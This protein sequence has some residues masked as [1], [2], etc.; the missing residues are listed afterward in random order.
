M[1]QVPLNMVPRDRRERERKAKVMK[2]RGIEKNPRT[3]CVRFVGI[4]LRR[5]R[6][7]C[8]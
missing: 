5:D 1:P 3:G 2:G 4:M 8:T 6:T 7:Y